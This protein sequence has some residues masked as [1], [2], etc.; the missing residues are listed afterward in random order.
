MDFGPEKYGAKLHI[1]PTNIPWGSPL[2]VDVE[3]DEKDNFVGMAICYTEKEVS[4]FTTPQL[5]I[6]EAKLI[7]HGGKFDIAMLQKWG[8]DVKISQLLYDT[9]VL[10]YMMDSSKG[11]Y[12]LKSLAKE[13]LGMEWPSYKEMVGTG[14]KKVTLDKQPVERVAAYCGCDALATFR[15]YKYLIARLSKSQK[16]YLNEIEMPFY[17][18]LYKMEQKGIQVNSEHL[19][20][21]DTE[22]QTD[23]L[24]L[25]LKLKQYGDFNPRSPKQVV[26]VLKQN[27]VP[28]NSSDSRILKDFVD[29]E[30]VKLLLEFREVSKLR[31]TYTEPLLASPTLPRIYSY[32]NPTRTVTG[33]LASSKP[34]L[35]NIPT[36]TDK[37]HKL[38]QA[39]CTKPGY[40]LVVIDY[41][42]IE[43][44]LFAH[45]SQDPVL[46][47]AYKNDRDVHDETA[48]IIGADRR[49]GK[50]LNFAAIYGASAKRISQTGD[51]DK[52]RADDLLSRYWS[53]LSKAASWITRTKW[54]ARKNE[55]VSTFFGRFIPL[56]NINSRNKFERFAKERQAVNYVI[57]GSAAEIIKKAMIELDDKGY[58]PILQVHDEL[59]FEVEDGRAEH[60]ASVIKYI[61]ESVVQLT[62]ALKVDVK[63]ADNWGAK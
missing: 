25:E 9:K 48:K 24:E 21:L 8:C 18:S 12:G 34:N 61:M 3:T 53:K 44:R 6:A 33:R 5:W 7:T 35:Q 13:H 31:S 15:L 4:Y 62:V 46:L 10:G 52:G 38:R 1:N 56:P 19:R 26:K 2:A 23:I 32:F 51:I 60:D 39:F 40:K 29:N 30:F 50:T 43:Y 55:G 28:V 22:F 27:N 17:R 49:V 58:V 11:R 20:K 14:K 16:Q 54:E 63:I 41:S 45:F 37:G 47:E 57:Q 36:R 42:Q 59:I